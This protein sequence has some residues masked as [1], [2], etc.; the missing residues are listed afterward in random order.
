MLKRSPKDAKNISYINPFSDKSQS[1]RENLSEI[2]RINVND[3]KINIV[4]PVTKNPKTIMR[5]NTTPFKS[6]IMLKN[7][8]SGTNDDLTLKTERDL[9]PDDIKKTKTTNSPT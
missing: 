1:A 3:S 7:Q 6:N 4:K 9:S 2:S 5:K 8:A